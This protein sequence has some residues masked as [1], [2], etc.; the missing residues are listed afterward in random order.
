[1]HNE[2]KDKRFCTECYQA[3]H[4]FILLS[5][6]SWVEFWFVKVVPKYLSSSTLSKELLP[7]FI[8][9]LR[10][11]FRSRDM[12]TY[13]VLSAF[14]S[15]PVYLLATNSWQFTDAMSY[16]S[17]NTVRVHAFSSVCQ[18]LVN[19]GI[20]LRRCN[21][22]HQCRDAV[23]GPD[24]DWKRWVF[25]KIFDTLWDGSCNGS[26]KDFPLREQLFAVSSLLLTVWQNWPVYSVR[27][28]RWRWICSWMSLGSP[29]AVPTNRFVPRF[30]DGFGG[31]VVGMLDSSTQVCGFKP[32]RSRWIF[33][34]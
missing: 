2:L 4:V 23:M 31:L 12:T 14:T 27:G 20:F 9:W 11:A 1:M 24:L 6:S 19:P 34:T 22:G 8:L 25:K 10:P 5:I 26:S 17:L 3:F 30:L 16:C 13:W 15:S 32:G 7:V 28:D 33:Q 29:M 18:S 21:R